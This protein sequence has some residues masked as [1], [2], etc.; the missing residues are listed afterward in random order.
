MSKLIGLILLLVSAPLSAEVIAPGRW[1]VASTA[2]DVVIPGAPD[3]LLRMMKGKSKSERKCLTRTMADRGVASLLVPDPKAQCHVDSEQI[4]DGRYA[5]TLTCPQ[6]RGPPMRIQRA[7]RYDPSGFSG[8]L[9]M[10]G[11]TPKGPMH[12]RLTQK[13]THVADTCEAR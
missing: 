5:Q 10:D 7:G 4:G 11:Q 13:A 1:D 9:D 6:R 8:W 3:F 2:V 12:V